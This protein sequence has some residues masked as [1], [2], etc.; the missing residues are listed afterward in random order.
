MDAG[1]TPTYYDNEAQYL[2]IA[3]EYNI[4][5][6]DE[7][8]NPSPLHVEEAPA[9]QEA[10]ES[11]DDNDNGTLNTPIKEVPSARGEVVVSLLEKAQNN[12]STELL[13][14]YRC[15]LGCVFLLGLSVTIVSYNYYASLA[16]FPITWLVVHMLIWCIVIGVSVLLYRVLSVQR[17]ST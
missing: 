12:G 4:L 14:R 2:A 16:S 3:T 7:T 13:E 17:Q 11:D 5:V 10:Q 15:G 8:L 9:S 1:R 6:D